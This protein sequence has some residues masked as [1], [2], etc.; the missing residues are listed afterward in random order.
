M[1]VSCGRSI[2]ALSLAFLFGCSVASAADEWGS[3]EGQFILEGDVP[4]LP[5]LVEKGNAAAKDAAVCA[6]SGVPD[7]SLIVNPENLGIANVCLYIRKAPKKIHPDLKASAE[8]QVVFDQVGCR[9][10]PHLLI[11][12][13]DQVVLVK[14]GDPINH[15]TRTSPFAN[16]AENL[17]IKPEERTGVQITMKQSELNYPPV[18]V[19]CDIHPHMSAYWMV[20]DHPY[21]AITDAD[22]KFKIENLP[23]GEHTFR[24]WHERP[25][26]INC[27]E[28]KR[29]LKVTV[30]PGETTTLA[31]F[32]V[33]VAEFT[34]TK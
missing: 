6:A 19:S 27:G 33:P 8:P 26:Y 5:A 25:G 28:F 34:K 24:V 12:R 18:K 31:P 20:A 11:V 14:S 13:T 10:T 15:N 16:K 30:K 32:K 23:V 9:F 7:D 17:I 22:G 4:E 2:A 29:D 1:H 3:I 21:V